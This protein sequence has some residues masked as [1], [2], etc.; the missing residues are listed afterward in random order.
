MEELKKG[1]LIAYGCSVEKIIRVGKIFYTTDL[2]NHIFK[3]DL[4]KQNDFRFQ[5]HKATQK[6]LELYRHYLSLQEMN[7]QIIVFQT[8]K[9][10]L[11]TIKQLSKDVNIDRADLIE[12]LED[13]VCWCEEC[14]EDYNK[15]W[16]NEN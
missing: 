5:Y 11:K 15:E 4:S 14:I 6:D 7:N 10:D 8:F 1:D 2:Q 9:S 13:I 3:S 16:N 12:R